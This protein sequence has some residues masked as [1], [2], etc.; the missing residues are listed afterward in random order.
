MARSAVLSGRTLADLVRN[1]L[2][3]IL[4]VVVGFAV[5]F[6]IHS[7][8]LSFAGAIALLLAFGFAMS[9]VFAFIGLLVPNAESAQAASF[10]IL[11]LLVFASIAFVPAETMP[12]WLQAYNEFQPVS[13]VVE[14]VRALS[15]GGATA[16][17]VLAA[18]GWCVALVAVFAPLSVRR[19]RRAA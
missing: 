12:G 2:V 18:L 3:V 7:S 5:G 1:L 17:Q 13:V 14:A 16:G 4:M 6:D 11:A 15:L 8:W 9:W 19:Y 10:P